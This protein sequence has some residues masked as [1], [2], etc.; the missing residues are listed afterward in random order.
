MPTPGS[1]TVRRRRLAVELRR[2]READGRTGDEVAAALDW[3]PSKIS[4]YELART[5]LKPAEVRKLLDVYGV[6]GHQR[7]QLLALADEATQKGWWEDYADAL[8]AEYQ[9]FIGLEAEARS[10][11]HWHTEVVPGLLQTE[12]YARQVHLGYQ[13]VVPI[14]PSVVERRVKARLIRQQLL[15]RDPPL[16][17]SVV[18]DE[19]VLF[20]RFG[21]RLTM[22]DQLGRLAA[23]SELPN[24]TVQILPLDM[25]HS[26]AA[27]SFVIFRFGDERETTLHD[28]VS[29]ELLRSEL[30]VEGEAET[31]QLRLAFE[32]LAAES[33][34]PAE[35][36]DLVVRTA[37]RL[38]A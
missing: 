19:S 11:S 34:S 32:R 8:P 27:G 33:L 2:L 7:D 29:T 6:T 36:R 3:S 25:D 15:V 23:A 16:E 26:I 12:E 5:G 28:V 17:L 30:H 9:A 20:R 18:L 21:D 35:S 37:R 1:P 38:W 4:R 10:V 24:V 13:K 14:P 22:R 31:Y